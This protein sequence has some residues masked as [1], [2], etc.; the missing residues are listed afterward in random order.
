MGLKPFN[1]S[2]VIIGRW[3]TAI[4][5]PARI[6]K[7]IFKLPKGTRVEV[8]IP[9][10]GIMPYQVKHPDRNII[11]TAGAQRLE[12]RL[13]VMKYENLQ[14]ALE[15][16]ASA[17]EWLPETPVSAAG[18]NL[19]FQTDEPSAEMIAL[20]CNPQTDS[21]FAGLENPIE[22]WSLTR[23]MAFND[24]FLKLT[25]LG[26]KGHFEMQCNFH[27]S[28]NE[29]PELIAWLRKP[30]VEIEGEVDR[31]FSELNLEREENGNE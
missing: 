6:S 31:V 7:K 20:Y 12:I 3:N 27:R 15:A 21:L 1:W 26:K 25:T 13:C 18:Y 14:H 29:N 11:L 9:T 17:L 24:G 10:D 19:N 4:L 5:T 28:S 8:A 2:V 30:A 16:G 22:E 23:S